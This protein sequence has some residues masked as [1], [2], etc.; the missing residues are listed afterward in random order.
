MPKLKGSLPGDDPAMPAK[1]CEVAISLT[2][3][4]LTLICHLEMY[5]GFLSEPYTR[6]TVIRY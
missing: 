3:I 6:T 5:R 1:E 4:S 2:Q